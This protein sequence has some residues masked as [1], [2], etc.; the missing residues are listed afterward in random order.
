MRYLFIKE[1][2]EQFS[3]SALCRVMAVCRGGFYAWC[4]REKSARQLE[5]ERLTEQ[6]KAVHEESDE[7]YGSP[8]I[9]A[10]LK[11]AGVACSEKR[12]AR[13]MRLHQ[14]RAVLPK[15]FVVTTDSNHDIPIAENLLDRMFDAETPDT[16]WTTGCPLGDHL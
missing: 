4:K 13:L 6:I 16:R 1:Y 12:I 14:I 7:T 5:N 10:E 11:E 3:L 15:R 9:F 8:R 2:Q